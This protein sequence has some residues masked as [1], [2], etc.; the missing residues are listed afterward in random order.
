MPRDRVVLTVEEEGSC[1]WLIRD[2]YITP[3]LRD[4]MNEQLRR[5]DSGL[6]LQGWPRGRQRGARLES[7]GPVLAA[8]SWPVC[9]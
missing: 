5:I 9:A 6:W 2:G 8:P 4:E 7:S 3:E 1:T